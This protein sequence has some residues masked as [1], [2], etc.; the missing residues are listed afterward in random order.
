MSKKSLAVNEQVI[1]TEFDDGAGVLVDVQRKRYYQLN[2]TS[3]LVWRG[4]QEGLG[5]GEIIQQITSRYEVNE[6]EV[7]THVD[8]LISNLQVRQLTV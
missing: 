1:L 4:L 5:T 3:L 2:E 7:A 8:E 6:N